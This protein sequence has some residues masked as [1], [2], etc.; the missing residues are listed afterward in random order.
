MKRMKL[1]SSLALYGSLAS[2]ITLIGPAGTVHAQT[3]PSA[4]PALEEV[5]VN[6]RRT[7][8]NLQRVPVTVTALSAAALEKQDIRTMQDLANYVPGYDPC[9][10]RGGTSLSWMRGVPGVVGYFSEL[11][12]NIDGSGLFF[13]VSNIQVLKG[14]QGTLFGIATNGGAVLSQPVKPTNRLEGMTS[15]SVGDFDRIAYEGV[16][17]VPVVDDKFL[18]RVGFQRVSSDGYIHDLTYGKEYG[19]DDYWIGR[20]SAIFRPNDRFE[21]YFVANYSVDNGVPAPSIIALDARPELG[22]AIAAFGAAAVAADK[23]EQQALGWYHGYGT[24][25]DAKY[26]RKALNLVDIAEYNLTDNV[27][28]RNLFGFESIETFSRLQQA[29]G[30]LPYGNGATLG[31]EASGPVDTWTEEL[32]LQG[33]IFDNRLSFTVGS[34][35]SGS[36][37]HELKPTYNIVNGGPRTGSAAY[38]KR[39]TYALYAQGT[40]DLSQ[41]ID[42]LS[43]TAGYRYTWDERTYHETF[44]DSA[45]VQ[46]LY[47]ENEGKFA[48]PSYTA[49]VQYQI[50]QDVMVFLTDS[51][52]TSSGGFNSGVPI[53][54]SRFEPES[55]DNIELGVKGQFEIGGMRARTNISAYY[56]KYTDVQA[57]NLQSFGPDFRNGQ[58]LLYQT[59][60]ASAIIKGI[61]SEI[62]LV[63]TDWLELTSNFQYGDTYYTKY[64]FNQPISATA[65]I[66]VDYSTAPF[67][68]FSK[69]KYGFGTVVHFAFLPQSI[70]DVSLSANWSWK[71]KIYAAGPT[72]HPDPKGYRPAFGLLDLGARWTDIMQNTHLE[73]TLTVTNYLNEEFGAGHGLGIQVHTP[74]MISMRLAYTF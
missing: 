6:A 10:S 26:Y 17:N 42:G 51:K 4:G 56:G 72:N 53:A 43:A 57:Y 70:G 28:V 63:P 66:P 48:K 1:N 24:L 52:G 59:N 67:P 3:A 74:R 22:A 34:F 64:I 68:G 47:Q 29:L 58:I 32:Q 15:V 11:P 60:A 49:G 62:T 71:S 12:A 8:E 65:T 36:S 14:P 21:N 69:N 50:N 37:P 2:A 16:L 7:E 73:G 54:A 30:R 23:A 41:F 18:V 44:F 38:N 55:L 19:G 13:D 27:K 20:V 9:C 39:K 25:P 61:E 46:T 5:I 35:N 31:S 33:Q 40:Y 45:G